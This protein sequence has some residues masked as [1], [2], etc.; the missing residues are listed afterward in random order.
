[1]T[2][3]LQVE[4]GP[5]VG[6]P[7]GFRFD[8]VERWTWW[9]QDQ[10]G[11]DAVAV[12]GGRVV[13]FGSIAECQAGF[14]IRTV[15]LATRTE[16]EDDPDPVAADLGPAQDWVRGKRLAV[17]LESVLNLWNWGIDV[18]YST[19]LVFSQRAKR[20]DVCY[21]KLMAHHAPWMFGV[22]EY[23]PIWSVRELAVLRVAMERS[24]HVLRTALPPA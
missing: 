7:G 14:P 8:G 2:A 17:P 10:Y 16:A 6:R 1:M 5:V 13:T 11:E 18:A 9:G 23:H 20:H 4:S 3:V 15:A 19:G 12:R 21:D 22:E 24:V